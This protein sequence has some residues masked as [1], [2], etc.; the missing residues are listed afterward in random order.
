MARTLVGGLVGGAIVFI[1]NFLF[2]GTQLGDIPFSTAGESQAAAVQTA[3]AQNLTPNG[4]GTY[5]IPDPDTGGGAGPV[6]T[7]FFDIAGY[8]PFGIASLLPGIIL[9][10]LT[11]LL[12]AYGLASLNS[13]RRGFGELAR[14]VV[15]LALG[16]SAWACLSNPVFLH[17]DWRYWIYA[18]VV[19]SLS[20]IVAGL[21]IARWFVSDRPEAA[22]ASGYT[23]QPG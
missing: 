6:A 4:T 2:W 18:F 16:Y 12:I 14:L 17:S 3:L 15:L 5:L 7:V 8:P 19:N 1:M 13:V 9:A 21:V 10:L 20:L 22:A 11:G 23:A